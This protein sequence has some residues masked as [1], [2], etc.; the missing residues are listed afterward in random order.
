MGCNKKADSGARHRQGL[1][2]IWDNLKKLIGM[3]G[4]CQ[5]HLREASLHA[6]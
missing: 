4:E 3:S 1:S 2:G 5:R 6:S